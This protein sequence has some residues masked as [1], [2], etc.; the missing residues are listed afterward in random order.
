MEGSASSNRQKWLKPVNPSRSLPLC[1]LDDSEAEEVLEEPFADCF[2]CSNQEYHTRA[3]GDENELLGMLRREESFDVF[4]EHLPQVT[5]PWHNTFTDI[6]RS[7]HEIK[8]LLGMQRRDHSQP[9]I[10]EGWLEKLPPKGV[11][12][13]RKTRYFRQEGF[14]L[15]YYKHKPTNTDR[16]AWKRKAKGFIDLLQIV[17]VQD[18]LD[19][20]LGI[21]WGGSCSSALLT[22]VAGELPQ[23]APAG[24]KYGFVVVT[25]SR[26]YQL[27]APTLPQQRYWVSAFNSFLSLSKRERPAAYSTRARVKSV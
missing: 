18:S 8:L 21:K 3:D 4:H 2:H 22:G 13:Q 6:P 11:V 25:P 10:L 9:A 23:K 15:W 27:Y 14:F 19:C 24:W 17:D 20:S 1:T 26:S 16:R 12:K 5:S 7:K